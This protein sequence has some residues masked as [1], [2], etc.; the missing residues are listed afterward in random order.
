MTAV[1]NLERASRPDVTEKQRE[2]CKR[3]IQLGIATLV[4]TSLVLGKDVGKLTHADINVGNRLYD[5]CCKELGFGV[6]DARR[7][8]TP[9]MISL[10]QQAA[11]DCA[12][13]IKIA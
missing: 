6:R 13:R 8:I 9:V 2:F 12:L 1:I 11:K 4:I 5:S 3:L 10:I 7:A